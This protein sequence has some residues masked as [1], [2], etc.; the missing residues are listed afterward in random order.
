MPRPTGFAL[1]AALFII[2]TMAA[3]AVYLLTIST[4]QTAAATQDEQATRAYQAARAGI[5]WGAF[6]ILR[7]PAAAFAAACTGG[8]GTASQTLPLGTMGGG[9]TATVAYYAEVLCDRIGNEVEG[10]APVRVYRIR[11]TGCNRT[12]CG[13]AD[14]TYVERQL[15]LMLAE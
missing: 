7:N 4:G 13:A 3:I 15:Q 14:A 6:Q 1:M 5:D 8:A 12:P 11:V 10:G 9:A 2:V